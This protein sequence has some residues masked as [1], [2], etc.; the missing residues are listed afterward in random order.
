MTSQTHSEEIVRASNG[1]GEGACVPAAGDTAVVHHVTLSACHGG[2]NWAL[3]YCLL[4]YNFSLMTTTLPMKWSS[5]ASKKLHGCL[6]ESLLG[7]R[8]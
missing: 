6:D 2:G 5:Q 1:E 3:K 4:K 8:N 7:S